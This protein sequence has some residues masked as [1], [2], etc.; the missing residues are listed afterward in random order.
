LAVNNAGQVVCATTGTSDWGVNGCTAA[1]IYQI[2]LD[3]AQTTSYTSLGALKFAYPKADT[4]IDGGGG[5]QNCINQSGQ[6]VGYEVVGAV[7][8]AAIW[9]NGK[10]IDLQTYFAGALPSNFV[11][12]NATAVSDNGYIAGYGTDGSGDAFQAFRVQ[13]LPGDA[14]LDGK[15]DINDLTIVLTNYGTS[16]GVG[17]STGDFNADGKVDINDLTIVL[18]NYGQSLSAAAG[19]PSAA[20]EPGTLVLTLAAGLLGLLAYVRRKRG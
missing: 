1:Y 19:G 17:W 12:N 6:V 13:L 7:N 10:L 3:P 2:G 5:F 16:S 9:Q 15:V 11:L 8:H 4:L 20:P 14:N 18:S